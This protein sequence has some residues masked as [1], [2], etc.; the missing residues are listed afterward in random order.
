MARAIAV[1]DV[2]FDLVEVK[3]AAAISRLR[4]PEV[5]RSTTPATSARSPTR[6]FPFD[7]THEARR[8]AFQARRDHRPSAAVASSSG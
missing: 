2:P 1:S 5:D 7:Q 3:L 8:T 6:P 4:R